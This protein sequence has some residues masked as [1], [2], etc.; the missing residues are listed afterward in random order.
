MKHVRR[1]LA[2][3][4][5]LWIAAALYAWW[6]WSP[7][8]RTYALPEARASAEL[9]ARL[10]TPEEHD[11]VR[12][13]HGE[14]YV[15]RL[16]RGDGELLYF[17]A[18]HA[19]DADDPQAAEIRLLWD[20]FRPTVALC[21]GRRRGHFVGP[22]FA[23]LV[24]LPEPALVH[25]LARRDEVELFSLEPDYA[26]EVAR[27]L[28][29]FDAADVALFFTLRV[30]WSES[31]GAADEE[32]ADDLRAK[33]TDVDGLRGALAD[34]AAMD[35]AWVR[36]G[37]DGDWRTWTGGMVGVLREIDLASRRVR[38]EHMARVLIDLVENGERVF[39]VVGSGHVI[40]Q[41]PALRAALGEEPAATGAEDQ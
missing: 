4:F 8:A 32:L 5:A 39:A 7:K 41:E 6:A 10:R 40:R 2:V 24:G 19:D 36:S 11:R 37:A 34:T 22:V 13:E 33:R 23:R 9:P 16:R 14:P 38:G 35:A 25:E 20:G 27:L 15:L 21:E 1:F 26:T 18:R 12:A 28:D 30:Y 17:G 29:R 3:A 31:G